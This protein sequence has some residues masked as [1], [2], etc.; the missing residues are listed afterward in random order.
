MRQGRKFIWKKHS[1]VTVAQ[2][3][4]VNGGRWFMKRRSLIWGN[5]SIRAAF[6]FPLFLTG[7][8][9]WGNLSMRTMSIYHSGI[10]NKRWQGLFFTHNPLCLYMEH[11]CC[12][13]FPS[14]D[15]VRINFCVKRYTVQQ[16]ANCY[17]I[18]RNYT[19]H[20]SEIGLFQLV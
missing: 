11:F 12:C 8:H 7:V 19:L 1:A 4:M 16:R 3:W 14:A 5:N 9:Y 20:S 13:F 15:P 17:F 10:F 18:S 6:F 2:W